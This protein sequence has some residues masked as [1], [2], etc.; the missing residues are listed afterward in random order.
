MEEAFG[1]LIKEN[2]YLLETAFDEV[3]GFELAG[4]EGKYFHLKDF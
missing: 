3:V 4:R 2:Q 1:N